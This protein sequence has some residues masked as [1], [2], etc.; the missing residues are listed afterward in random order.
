MLAERGAD[1]N[2]PGWLH[3]GDEMNGKAIYYAN[4]VFLFTVRYLSIDL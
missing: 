4:T 2:P 1:K 3:F